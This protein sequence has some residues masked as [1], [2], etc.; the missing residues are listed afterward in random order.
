MQQTDVIVKYPLGYIMY[1]TWKI[2]LRH[3]S[4]VGS[5]PSPQGCVE[6]FKEQFPDG[7]RMTGVPGEDDS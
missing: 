1:L 6:E 4:S 2:S 3:L 7:R 5:H